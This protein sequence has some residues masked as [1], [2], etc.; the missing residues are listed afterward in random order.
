[1]LSKSKH[2]HHLS[3]DGTTALGIAAEAECPVVSAANI[4]DFGW[5][6]RDE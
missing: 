2:I 4:V 6:G 5:Q 3:T 1:M